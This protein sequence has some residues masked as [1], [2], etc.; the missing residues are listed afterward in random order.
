[1]YGLTR[2]ILAGAPHFGDK[3]DTGCTFSGLRLK[4]V[5]YCGPHQG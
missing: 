4:I 3:Y 2:G 5:I 1:M